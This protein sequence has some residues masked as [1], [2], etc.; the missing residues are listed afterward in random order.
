MGQTKDHAFLSPSG[1]SRWMECP[2]SV[3]LEQQYVHTS[4]EAADEGTFAHHVA[5]H[6]IKNH[7]K[8]ISKQVFDH[9]MKMIKK[10]RFF[11]KELEAHCYDFMNVVVDK[12]NSLEDA[13]IVIEQ[14]VDLSD[15][16]KEG[17]GTIDIMIVSN[18]DLYIFDL[19]YGKGVFVD[20]YKNKQL[21]IYALGA[22]KNIELLYH[23]Q[24]VKINIF[25]PRL[26][27]FSS[28]DI[29]V[30]ALVHWGMNILKPAAE[31]AFNGKGDYKAGDHCK[32]CKAKTGC[33]TLYD[34]NM[35]LAQLAFKDINSLTDADISNVLSKSDL[36]KSWLSDIE[37]MALKEATEKNKKWPGFKLVEG[38]SNRKYTNEDAIIKTLKKHKYKEDI[39]MTK[40]Q[41]VGITALEKNLGKNEMNELIGSYIHKPPGSPTLVPDSDKRSELDK[42]EQARKVFSNIIT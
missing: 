31:L 9:E 42:I 23:T 35:S 26:N 38:R 15:Y 21:M 14:T 16:I 10:H 6:L 4:N 41:L 28:Y 2:P 40:P 22:L 36:F 19:K 25:Q 3:H 11:S 29:T 1:A 17:Y 8:I 33:K 7:F 37:E 13:T 30:G 24:N 12:Y 5:E 32:F 39:Y 20:A 34:Y 27:N 18:Y